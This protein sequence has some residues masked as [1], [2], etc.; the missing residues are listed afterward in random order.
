MT[1]IAD[2]SMVLAHRREILFRTTGRIPIFLLFVLSCFGASAQLSLSDCAHLK[3]ESIANI[4]RTQKGTDSMAT[5]KLTAI[6]SEWQACVIN[7]KVPSF[8]LFSIKDELLDSAGLKGKILMINFWFTACAPCVAELPG[9]NRLVREYADKNVIFIGF[10][11]EDKHKIVNDFLPEHPFDFKIVPD[12]GGM[13]K[14]FGVDDYPTTFII[15][16]SGKV[17]RAWSGGK[18]GPEAQEEV[19]LK[20]KQVIDELLKAK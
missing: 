14:P 8:R 20:A 4:V 6:D 1:Q 11:F 3:T 5:Q 16:A 17:R 18:V 19:Y 15:D 10:T 2:S 9:L 12:A 7:A 13:E